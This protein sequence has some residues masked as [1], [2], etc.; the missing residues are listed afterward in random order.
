M[1]AIT[2]GCRAHRG[3]TKWSVLSVVLTVFA[4]AVS[5]RC[6]QG[7]MANTGTWSGIIINSNCTLDQAFAEADECLRNVPGAPLAFYDDTTRQIFHL[8]PPDQASGHL[9]DAVTVRGTLEGDTLHLASLE[10]LKGFGLAVGQKAPAFTAHDQ[11]GHEQ[12]LDT[13]RGPRGTALLFF[14]SADW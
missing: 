3:V 4:V 8:D 6:G 10:L 12:T 2:S 14:R 13:L 1:N 7:N 9:G 5:A 11:F